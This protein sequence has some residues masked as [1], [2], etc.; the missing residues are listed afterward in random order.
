MSGRI[1]PFAAPALDET[2]PHSVETEQALLGAILVNN[3]ALALVSVLVGPEHFFV[4]E[5]ATIFQQVAAMVS[6]GLN[7]NALTLK[8]YLGDADL[9]GMTVSQYLA[10]LSAEASTVSGA[11]GYAQIIRSL[12]TRRDLIK[13]ARRMEE[14]ARF[15]G[16][17][18]TS[19]EIIDEVEAKLQEIRLDVSRLTA[20]RKGLQQITDTLLAAIAA[21]RSG[22]SSP[23]PTSGFKDIDRAIGGGLRAGR[24]IVLAGRPGMGKTILG[25]GIARRSA[26]SGAGAAFFSLEIDDE[27]LGARCIADMLARSQYP[28]AYRDILAGQELTDGDVERIQTAALTLERLPLHLDAESGL[29]IAQIAARAKAVQDHFRKAG[30]PLGVVVID[31]LGLVCPSDRYRGQKV[32]E[33]GEIALACKEMAKKLGVCVVLLAQLNRGV[34]GREDK[35]PLMSDLRDSGNIEEHADVVGLLYRPHYYT[36][37]SPGFRDGDP[38]I[39]DR[40]AQQEHVL[41]LGLGKNR[42]GPTGNVELWCSVARS[43]VRDVQRW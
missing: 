20:P 8:P 27:E 29:T 31:Y 32:D 23:V 40:A 4:P 12:A 26:K 34:E 14:R 19:D 37:N 38:V 16:V 10:R 42:L 36:V 1:V 7:A 24:L 9:G 41:H 43:A 17:E 30:T 22:T 18:V 25:L 5:H 2:L 11:P 6:A 21:A 33:V 15:G 3:D 13:A 28:L 39:V 35:R